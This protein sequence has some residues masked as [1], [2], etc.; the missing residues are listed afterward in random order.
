M[1]VYPGAFHRSSTYTAWLSRMI[2]VE[3]L[4]CQSRRVAGLTSTIVSATRAWARA[5]FTTAFS[6]LFDPLVLLQPLEFA[7][8]VAQEARRRH[9]RAVGQHREVRQPQVDTHLRIDLGQRLILRAEDE[10]G[11]VPA[12]VSRPSARRLPSEHRGEVLGE[13]ER[14]RLVAAARFLGEH[15][16]G[17][18]VG[19]GPGATADRAEL[20]ATAPATQVVDVA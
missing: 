19:P 2:R 12:G 20:A 15:V 17:D 10:R 18:R 16:P 3:S 11:E 8:G 7:G 9:L 14:A 13:A 1:P 5:S 4:C 6:P